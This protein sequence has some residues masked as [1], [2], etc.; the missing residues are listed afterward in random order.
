MTLK[1]IIN[2]YFNISKKGLNAEL[3]RLNLIRKKLN[4]GCSCYCNSCAKRDC[5]LYF[6]VK[7]AHQFRMRE[8]DVMDAVDALKK[9]SILSGT[10]K[11]FED[12]YYAVEKSIS[13][14]NG[15]G[16]LTVYD[17]AFRIGYLLNV[18]PQ[19][20][21]YLYAG[22]YEGYKRLTNLFAPNSYGKNMLTALQSLDPELSRLDAS[23]I[24][25]FFCVCK[26]FFKVVNNTGGS[27]SSR[28]RPP[29][30][31]VKVSNRIVKDINRYDD[32]NLAQ[33][34]NGNCVVNL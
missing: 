7:G 15:I 33:L 19:T 13:K 6:C 9:N 29:R 2:F 30:D 21:A 32:W 24:E 11:D 25:N 5:L 23:D 1:D 17:T 18:K 34:K 31:C 4:S 26:N 3:E 16:D 27:V 28:I 14:C 8:R 12:L 10:Y 20:Y 22:G